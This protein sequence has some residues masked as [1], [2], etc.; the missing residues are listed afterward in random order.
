MGSVSYGAPGQGELDLGAGPRRRVDLGAAA[1][2]RHAPD[3]RLAHAAAVG[4][5]GV[6]AEAGATVADVDLDLAVERLGV[7]VDGRAAAELRPGDHRLAGGRDE[8]LELGVEV[9][10]AH[11]DDLD[12]NAV[13]ALDL[14]RGD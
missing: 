3:D 9:G 5:Q 2:A 11:R 8:R 1:V 13:V 4:W 10:V 12:C 14:A 6:G 7:D